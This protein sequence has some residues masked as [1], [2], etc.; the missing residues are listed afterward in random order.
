[1]SIFI[2][3]LF[4]FSRFPDDV[5]DEGQE[6]GLELEGLEQIPPEKGGGYSLAPCI[7]PAFFKF[8]IA[9]KGVT[10][11][12][13]ESDTKCR[14]RIPRKGQEG[15]LGEIGGGGGGWKGEEWFE[16]K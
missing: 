1:M 3:F 7:P 13:I 9:S 12:N 8:I 2:C 16:G 14:L 5:Y 6:S 11:A 10:R 4:F 15:R